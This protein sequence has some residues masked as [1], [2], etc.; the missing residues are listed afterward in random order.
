MALNELTEELLDSESVFEGRII[1]LRV[2]TVRTPD[3]KVTTREVV[4]HRGAVAIVPLLD[5]HT[6]VLI[7][8]FRQ[9][10]G[11]VLIEIP[12]G[13][14]EPGESPDECARRELIEETGY[15]AGRMEKLFESYL[16]PGYSS[17]LLHVYAARDLVPVGNSL[18]EDEFLEVFTLP[19]A[20]APTAIRNGDVCDAKTLC[21]LLLVLNEAGRKERNDT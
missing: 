2:D 9:S 21:G 13:M 19:L 16:A 3:G 20:E 12:A 15:A 1:H 17:E 10:A 8:Q 4:E 14:L 6:V 18:D 5:E 7:R 11:R